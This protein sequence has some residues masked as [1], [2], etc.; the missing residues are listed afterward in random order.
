[1]TSENDLKEEN[2]TPN[3]VNTYLS[4]IK[5][6]AKQAARKEVITTKE[7]NSIADIKRISGSR[8]DKGRSLEEGGGIR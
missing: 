1:M 3:T 4:A 2:K 6:T 8:V 5:G 7:Y